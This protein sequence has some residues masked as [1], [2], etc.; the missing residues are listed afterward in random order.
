MASPFD[1]LFQTWYKSA[2]GIF[3]PSL[4][5]QNWIR[6]QNTLWKFLGRD[7]RL[8][9]DEQDIATIDR[10]SSSHH[11]IGIHAT[12]RGVLGGDT[13]KNL[14]KSTVATVDLQVI[15]LRSATCV[16]TLVAPSG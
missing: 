7:I 10:L 12:D 2:F 4:T 9:G 16:S 8:V 1:S 15:Q 11:T 13:L 3:L 14:K 5:V 6:M